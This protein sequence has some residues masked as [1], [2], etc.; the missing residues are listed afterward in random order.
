MWWIY[1]DKTAE[2]GTHRIVHAA[3]PGRLGRLAYTYLHL[4]IVAGI[5]LSAVGDELVLAH[6]HG[7]V[8]GRTAAAVIGGPFVYLAGAVSFKRAIRG[9]YQ[10]SHLAALGL[11]AVLAPVA[12]HLSPLLLAT[13]TAA[14]L[15]MV[16]IWESVSLAREKA[17]D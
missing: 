4:P 6:P 14:V 13:A 17:S 15:V 5:V 1:F 2:L 11:L 10:L 3:E 7:H 9:W 12:S 16:A 8:D